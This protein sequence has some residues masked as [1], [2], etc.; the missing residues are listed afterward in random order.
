[1]VITLTLTQ[2]E[3]KKVIEKLREYPSLPIP[4]AYEK[5]RHQVGDARVTVYAS[6]KVVIQAK[7]NEVEEAIHER[8]TKWL[9][10]E[11]DELVLGM[12]ET[13]R[14]ERHG[15]LVVSGVLGQRNQLRAV[16]DSKKTHNIKGAYH[17]A[18]HKSK[19]QVSVSFNAETIDEL[20]RKG[21]TLNEMES[22]AMQKIHE[23]INVFFPESITIADGKPLKKGMKGIIFQEKA[24]DTEPSVAAASI[25][26]KHTRN[27]SG[28]QNERKTWKRI[29]D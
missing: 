29:A 14:G 18:T 10:N 1:M 17:T 6:G 28:D 9:G 24:D 20:R 11:L 25:V 5:A 2:A 26:A 22:H 12:D 3:S 27:E 19:M 15:P 4:S 7:N 8:I 23:L 13:G 21:I 16:R